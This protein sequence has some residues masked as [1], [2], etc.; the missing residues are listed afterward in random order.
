MTQ[1]PG[2][3]AYYGK[4]PARGDFIGRRL[5]R[6][7]VAQWDGWLQQALAESRQALGPDWL[8]L[9][10][11]APLWR[12]VLPAGLC[13]PVPLAGV[14]M[15]S[16]DKVGRSFPMM[17]AVELPSGDEPAA[18]AEGSNLWFAALEELA[19]AALTEDFSL[20]RLDLPVAAL[21]AVAVRA[22][23]VGV[24]DRGGTGFGRCISLPDLGWAGRIAA[25]LL[26][27]SGESL[28]W[29]AGSERLR[30]VMV[31]ACGLPAPQGYAAFLDGEWARHGW[32]MVEVPADLAETSAASGPL[33]AT[34][35]DLLPWDRE[36]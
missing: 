33:S 24:A 27:S 29:T 16:V 10:L 15:Q 28:W 7:T 36:E 19:L 30:P 18:V 12:F 22:P 2:P 6:E 9:Y 20:E 23:A 8:D 21:P 3:L 14:L 13:G 1:P 32:S 11:T 17:L 5:P 31:A 4:L 25:R 34:D 26:S 35:A